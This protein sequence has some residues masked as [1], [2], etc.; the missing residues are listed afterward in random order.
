MKTEEIRKTLC[1]HGYCVVSCDDEHQIADLLRQSVEQ[2]GEL[3]V[4]QKARADGLSIVQFDPNVPEA[5]QLISDTSDAVSMHTDGS[6][7]VQPPGV[8]AMGYCVLE[9]NESATQI[10]DMTP[11]VEFLETELS[12]LLHQD[13]QVH[14]QRGDLHS[15]VPLVAWNGQ[16]LAMRFRTGLGIELNTTKYV[17]K[18]LQKIERDISQLRPVPLEISAGSVLFM[19]NFRMAHGR[20]TFEP[21]ECNRKILRAWY[22][23]AP[24]DQ[25]KLTLGVP[26]SGTPKL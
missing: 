2:L 18:I 5:E 19:D 14:I 22:T 12:E 26:F 10:V 13:S 24:R 25:I 9:R 15:K 6:Y 17:A 3:V 8:V 4:H 16:R 11:I 1:T 21:A 7:M 20:P 23:G